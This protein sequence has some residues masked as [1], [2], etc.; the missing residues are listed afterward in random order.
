MHPTAATCLRWAVV[1]AVLGAVLLVYGAPLLVALAER[2]GASAEIGLGLVNVV[3]TLV[4]S[5]GFPLAAALVGAAVVIQVLA[6]RD[7]SP[8]TAQ[9][10]DG[11]HRD[12][13]A[14]AG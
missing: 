12:A 6:P 8:A 5:L 13:E 10:A 7:G 1:S 4:T 11:A 14:G 2:A 3:L 9:R